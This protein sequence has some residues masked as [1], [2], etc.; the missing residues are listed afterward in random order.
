MNVIRRLAFK[1]LRLALTFKTLTWPDHS[2]LFLLSDASRWV[3]GEEMTSLSGICS[4]LGVRTEFRRR[5]RLY[6]NQ[7]VFLGDQFSILNPSNV[8]H[9][10]RI[11]LAYFHGRPGTGYP[12]STSCTIGSNRF[13]RVWIGSRRPINKCAT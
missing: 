2:R 5:Y 13:I 6:R 8:D 10:H 11:G 7:A 4:H 9:S 1:G 3:L 12:N